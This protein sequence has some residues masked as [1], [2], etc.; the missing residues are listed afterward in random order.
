MSRSNIVRFPEIENDYGE[1]V[2]EIHEDKAYLNFGGMGISTYNLPVP[3]YL[4]DAL[5]KFREEL[6][7]D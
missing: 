6:D 3:V 2:L 1:L 7:N 4:K 5:L